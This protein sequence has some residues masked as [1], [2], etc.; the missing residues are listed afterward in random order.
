MIT[1]AAIL[2]GVFLF[3]LLA[4]ILLGPIDGER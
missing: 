2:L 4:A 1:V 3:V